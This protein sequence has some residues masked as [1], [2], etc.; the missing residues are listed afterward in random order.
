MEWDS[1]WGIGF[2]G[3]H[4]ECSAMAMKHLGETLDIHCGGTD[5]IRVHHTNEIAQSECAT[6]KPF[7]RFWLHGGWLLEDKTR[8]G[9]K[10]SK[11]NEEFVR[12]D[13]LTQKGY[14]PF[15]YRYFCMTSHYRNYLKFSWESLNSAKDSLSNLRKKAS[16]FTLQA[17]NISCEN[18]QSWQEKFVGAVCDDLNLPNALGVLNLMLKDP[19]IPDGER[20]AL[21]RDF[22]K[23]LGLNLD[24]KP[25]HG[26][27]PSEQ[28]DSE[29]LNL[30]KERNAARAAK[31]FVRADEIRDIFKKR[32][33]LILDGPD[34]ST[35]KKLL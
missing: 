26:Q 25:E 32:G 24:E 34:G 11:S 8:G 19:D 1:P 4:L 15:D 29:L 30:M 2:P 22:E 6:G 18:A 20:G 23:I 31:N 5:H 10:M 13:T 33:F 9:G 27:A 16:T 12:L 3:W 28:P 17:T 14:S 7:A 35:W 21:I